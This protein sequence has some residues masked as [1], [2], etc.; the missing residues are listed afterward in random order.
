MRRKKLKESL[1]KDHFA[2]N[3]AYI[4]VEGAILA[5]YKEELFTSFKSEL[6]KRQ[7][8]KLYLAYS[9]VGVRRRFLIK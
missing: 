5:T 9:E 7:E 4:N 1:I 3:D 8:P 2:V 6:F